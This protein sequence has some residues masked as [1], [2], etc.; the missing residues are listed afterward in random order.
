MH[1]NTKTQLQALTELET[2]TLIQHRATKTNA[3][4]LV[5]TLDMDIKDRLDKIEPSIM[6][7]LI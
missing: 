5:E 4:N 7:K 2:L 1:I 3:W 6:K